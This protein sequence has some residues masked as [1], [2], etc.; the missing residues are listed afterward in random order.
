MNRYLGEIREAGERGRDLVLELMKFS[1]KD[2][3]QV[4]AAALEETVRGPAW[5]CLS[6]TALCT[7][8]IIFWSKPDAAELASGYCCPV[9]TRDV[10]VAPLLS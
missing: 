8:V 1:R 5:V 2:A 7:V 9:L 3:G 10:T 4:E 6:Y